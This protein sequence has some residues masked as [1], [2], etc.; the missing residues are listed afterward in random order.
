MIINYE[1][2]EIINNLVNEYVPEGIHDEFHVDCREQVA[3]IIETLIEKD[4][5]DS[6][7]TTIEAVCLCWKDFL[8]RKFSL[9]N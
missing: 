8:Y 7:D 4:V 1:T 9:L 2:K 3:E 5:I 6:D